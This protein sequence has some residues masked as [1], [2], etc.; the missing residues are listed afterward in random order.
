MTPQPIK[1]GQ[2]ALRGSQKIQ[3]IFW[4][5]LR[6][7]RPTFIGWGVIARADILVSS[8]GQ[9]TKKNRREKFYLG[10]I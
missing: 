4:E 2:G 3:R 7:P 8:R 5:P 6:A 9:M 10:K 1:V